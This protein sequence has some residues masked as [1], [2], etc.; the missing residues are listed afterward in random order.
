MSHL[1][2]GQDTTNI[3]TALFTEL[4]SPEICLSE[5]W[6]F[7]VCLH[8]QD[9]F[10]WLKL[11]LHSLSFYEIQLTIKMEVDSVRIVSLPLT[12]CN[13]ASTTLPSSFTRLK[14]GSYYEGKDSPAMSNNLAKSI[15]SANIIKNMNRVVS[16][17]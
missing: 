12:L 6:K 3:S 2:A 11:T 5:I 13:F 4:R 15:R 7:S 8:D 17:S 16:S 14:L 9:F 10:S 1:S